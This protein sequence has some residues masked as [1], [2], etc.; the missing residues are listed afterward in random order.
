VSIEENVS[1]PINARLA[2]QKESR[3]K[4]IGATGLGIL[5][6]NAPYSAAFRGSLIAKTAGM[7]ETSSPKF[8]TIW[9]L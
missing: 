7:V 9:S 4:F 5:K 2:G 6:E 3:L 8:W 1:G